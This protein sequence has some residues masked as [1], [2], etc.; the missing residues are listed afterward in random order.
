[1]GRGIRVDI[2]T[3]ESIDQTWRMGLWLVAGDEVG[4]WL[5]MQ[6]P[7]YG[8]Y[9]ALKCC[10]RIFCINHLAAGTYLVKTIIKAKDLSIFWDSIQIYDMFASK[11]NMYMCILSK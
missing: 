7:K 3:R 2:F 8:G 1:M 5:M 9:S 4:S 10:P 11:S 6:S